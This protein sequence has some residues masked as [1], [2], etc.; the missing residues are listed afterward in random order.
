MKKVFSLLI[1]LLSFAVLF[2]QEKSVTGRV[3]DE[4]SEALPGVNVI[5]KGTTIGTT[6]DSDGN[7]KISVPNGK[8]I[9]QFSFIGFENKEA[10][11]SK[12]IKLI[13]GLCNQP[14]DSKRW[15]QWVTEHR[16]R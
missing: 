1:L 12:P 2:A 11:M 7:F 3:T 15:W 9:L 5:V 4:N 6:T 14:S 8:T 13:S 16:R 10:D